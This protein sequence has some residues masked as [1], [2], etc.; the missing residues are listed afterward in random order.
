MDEPPDPGFLLT[1][2]EKTNE[3]DGTGKIWCD[4]LR[5]IGE[6]CKKTVW[7]GSCSQSLG[8]VVTGFLP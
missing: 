1:W 2:V 7:V 4:G 8:L 6:N 3:K 5:T